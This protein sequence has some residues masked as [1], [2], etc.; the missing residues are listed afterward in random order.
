MGKPETRNVKQ[1]AFHT[2]TSEFSNVIRI[3][4]NEQRNLGGQGKSLRTSRQSRL[5]GLNETSYQQVV[6]IDQ[7]RSNMQGQ[8]NRFNRL[9]QGSHVFAT[10][11]KPNRIRRAHQDLRTV[12]YSHLTHIEMCKLPHDNLLATQPASSSPIIREDF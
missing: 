11:A 1:I 6:K 5:A 4:K 2:L 8:K 7:Q 9:G 3:R 10:F 12:P